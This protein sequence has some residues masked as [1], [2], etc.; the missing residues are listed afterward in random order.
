MFAYA[1]HRGG[2]DS[3]MAQEDA[4]H[5]ISKK[6][7]RVKIYVLFIHYAHTVD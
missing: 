2:R 4:I 1:G 5:K 6:N 7:P 3:N